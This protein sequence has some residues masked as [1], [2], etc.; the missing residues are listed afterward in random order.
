MADTMMK[1]LEN[2]LALDLPGMS[3]ALNQLMQDAARMFVCDDEHDT[4]EDNDV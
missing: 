1:D 2:A 3:N 4:A